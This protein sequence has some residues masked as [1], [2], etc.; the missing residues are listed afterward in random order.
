MSYSPKSQEGQLMPL[1][2]LKIGYG[3]SLYKT[4]IF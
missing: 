1:E 2:L 4:F 3:Y